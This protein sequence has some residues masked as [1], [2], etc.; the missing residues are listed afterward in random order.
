MTGKT[1]LN[2]VANNQRD[3]L[4]EFT[5]LLQKEKIPF[6]VVGGLAVN[7]YAEPVVSL[8]LDMVIAADDHERLITSLPKD[9]IICRESHSTNVSASYSDLRIQLQ[10]D[11]RYQAF[12]SRAQMRNILGHDLPVAALEDVLQG[13]LWAYT[14]PQRRPSKRQKDLA[15]IMRLLESNP[16][17]ENTP[18]GQ[19][20]K[21]IVE[22]I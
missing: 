19:L 6:C 18:V 10:T 17:L 11:D 16:A 13:K 1:F 20:A 7:A 22:K 4:Q 3:L 5:Q 15:D 14:D 12:I 21:R 2:K 9:F 8:D